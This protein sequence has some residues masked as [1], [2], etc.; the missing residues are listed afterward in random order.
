MRVT[1]DTSAVLAVASGEPA[2]AAL[3]AATQDADF[4]APASLP[5]EIG[6]AL[7]AMLRRGRVD[8][9]R[10]LDI[11]RAVERIRVELVPI[12]LGRAVRLSSDLGIYAY[13]AYVLDC[14]TT[15]GTAL[16]SIDR[17]Q[18]TAAERAG[19]PLHPY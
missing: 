11:L 13:D 9:R 3:V 6:N 8:E 2:K 4:V 1:V 19:V 17:G 5:A 12:H 10:A 18:R 16:V 7:S 15:T 14:A